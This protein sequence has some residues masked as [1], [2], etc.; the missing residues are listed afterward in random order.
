[1]SSSKLRNVPIFFLLVLIVILSSD[2]L[3][4]C[5]HGRPPLMATQ[6]RLIL[7][8]PTT[9]TQGTVSPDAESGGGAVGIVEDARPTAPGHSPGAGHAVTNKNGVGRMLLGVSSN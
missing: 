2:Q 1:M 7:S 6:R 8:L 9:M 5:S 3:V 4:M